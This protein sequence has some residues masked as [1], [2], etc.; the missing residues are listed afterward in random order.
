MLVI[1]S[2]I[3]R[4]PQHKRIAPFHPQIH[5]S[6]DGQTDFGL[7]MAKGQAFEHGNTGGQLAAQPSHH[8]LH[9]ITFVVR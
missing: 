9:V 4:L 5:A 6:A 1:V 8:G 7:Y 3:M 2:M